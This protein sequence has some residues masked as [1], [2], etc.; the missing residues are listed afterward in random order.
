[1]KNAILLFLT[2]E[3]LQPIDI[4]AGGGGDFEG[5]GLALNKAPKSA[6]CIVRHGSWRLSGV[7][8]GVGREVG[9]SRAFLGR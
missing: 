6:I 1:M 2:H 5:R 8:V 3:F 4:G 7:A 9:K